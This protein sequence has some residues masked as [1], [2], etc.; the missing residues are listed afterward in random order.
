MSKLIL[1]RHGQASFGSDR[2]DCLS[3][4]GCVQARAT[5]RW[6]RGSAIQP[7]LLV[8]G[9]RQRQFETACMLKEQGGFYAPM[10]QQAELDEFA[11]GE[12]IFK[13]AELFLGR[14][15]RQVDGRS[16]LD[17]LRDYDVTCK[18]WSLGEI[19]IEGRSPINEFRGQV[20]QWF[21]N[22]IGEPD[23]SGQQVVAVTSAGVISALI[24][25]VLDL[26]NSKWHSLL[27]VIGNASLTELLFSKGRYSLSSF[28]GLAHLSNDLNSSM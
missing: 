12:E 1:M 11:E 2:Y 7:S 6:M 23:L 13:A 27:R 20:R 26:P 14:S 21:D 15:M 3:E 25:E 24:C 18:A 4:L 22:L 9:P 10:Q 5:G 19:Q 28:N 8:H 16:R 17:V